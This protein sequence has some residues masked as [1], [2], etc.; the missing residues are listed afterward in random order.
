MQK[1]HNIGRPMRAFGR[2]IAELVGTLLFG[3]LYV[4][5]FV[6]YAMLSKLRRRSY[7]PGF[8]EADHTYY[9][10]AEN[11]EPTLEYLRKQG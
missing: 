3:L 5:V 2:K 6:P 7:L 9:L 4:I 1:L 11:T 8:T 10:P